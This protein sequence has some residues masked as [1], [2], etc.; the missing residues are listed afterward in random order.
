MWVIANEQNERV[1]RFID[2]GLDR[3]EEAYKINNIEIVPEEEND[4]LVIP[5]VPLPLPR[6]PLA[7]QRDE[8][9]TFD[10]EEVN[11]IQSRLWNAVFPTPPLFIHRE[12]KEDIFSEAFRSIL[13][14]ITPSILTGFDSSTVQLLLEVCYSYLTDKDIQHQ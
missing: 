10:K 8:D 5:T 11:Q 1:V 14:S 9:E 3:T 6:E 7:P 4:D 2:N 12:S 13:D